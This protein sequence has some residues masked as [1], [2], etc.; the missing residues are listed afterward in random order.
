MGWWL[1]FIFDIRCL[2]IMRDSLYV[3]I[4]LVNM[5]E[6]IVK[7]FYVNWVGLRYWF[8]NYMWYYVMII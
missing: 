5:F 7:N 1:K 2:R 8:I 4:F 3:N 6:F